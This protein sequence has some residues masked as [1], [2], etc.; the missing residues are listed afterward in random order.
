M[1]GYIPGKHVMFCLKN[2]V[3]WIKARCY[4]SQKKN[5]KIH[6][7]Q[8][9]ISSNYPHHVAMAACSYVA[10]KAEMCSHVIG[11]YSSIALMSVLSLKQA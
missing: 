9:A 11:L 5:D 2:D 10:G 4:C 8:L 3:V 6:E 7:V 1:E